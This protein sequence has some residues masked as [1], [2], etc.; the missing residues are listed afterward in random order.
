[1]NITDL[2]ETF[3]TNMLKVNTQIK[4]NFVL[5]SGK[6]LANLNISFNIINLS[7]LIIYKLYY[8]KEVLTAIT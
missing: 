5:I 1:M 4:E 8:S 2:E 7:P 3:G 6:R